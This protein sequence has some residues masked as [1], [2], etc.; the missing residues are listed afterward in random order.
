MGV[1]ERGDVRTDNLLQKIKD[2]IWERGEK[3]KIYCL[4]TCIAYLLLCQAWLAVSQRMSVEMVEMGRL[5]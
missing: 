4:L 3:V 5:G 1:R 2:W